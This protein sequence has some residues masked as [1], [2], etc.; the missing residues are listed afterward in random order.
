MKDSDE[1]NSYDMNYGRGTKY[2]GLKQGVT[3]RKYYY[4][5][6]QYMHVGKTHLFTGENYLSLHNEV[7]LIQ[8]S[9]GPEKCKILGII[10]KP[11]RERYE[12]TT[13]C[14]IEHTKR[15]K[16]SILKM[17]RNTDQI[18]RREKY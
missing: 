4:L 7:I 13:M 1:M 11:A 17:E 12:T 5:V 8:E 3:G 9:D 18:E 15:R 2:D 14:N 10:M 6:I 16:V